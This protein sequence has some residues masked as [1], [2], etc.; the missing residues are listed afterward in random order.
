MSTIIAASTACQESRPGTTSGKGCYSPNVRADGFGATYSQLGLLSEAVPTEGCWAF[1][2]N[3]KLCTIRNYYWSERFIA[4]NK[5]EKPFEEPPI[6][7]EHRPGDQADQAHREELYSPNVRADGF[8]ATYS[9]LGLLSEAVPTEGCWTF[10]LNKRLCTIRNYYWRERFIARNKTEKPFEEPLIDQ[11][12]RPGDQADQAHREELY[13]PNVRAD[14]F[15]A[16]YSQLGLLSEAVPTEGCWT[17]FLNKRLCTIRNY[18]WSE[19]FIARNKTEKP[20]EE[21]P[22]DQE[23]RPG[24]QA[25]QAHREEHHLLQRPYRW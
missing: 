9:Q 15:G 14:G 5:T 24:D 11:E 7:Q 2:L 18:Y 17:F 13:S 21:P 23:H 25:D 12:H 20:F 22:I 4:R 19:R 1:F 16:T 3:K 6:D 10:F 8:G